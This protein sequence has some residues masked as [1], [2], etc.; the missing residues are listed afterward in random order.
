[1]PPPFLFAAGFLVAW[2]LER[3]LQF[4]INGAGAGPLQEAI[5]ATTMAM[6]FIF[7]AWGLATFVRARTAV[8][9]VRPARQLVVWG[10]YRYSRNPMYAGMTLLYIGLAVVLNTAWPLVLLPALLASLYALVIRP[11]ERYLGD[12]FGQ[13]YAD[14]RARVR[15]WI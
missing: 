8:L 10:P 1:M 12:A 7:M 6:G 3:R 15:R 9:P 5:G 13:E 11:E 14:Y 2:L 4:E